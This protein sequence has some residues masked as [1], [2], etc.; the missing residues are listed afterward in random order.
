MMIKRL[1]TA[2]LGTRFDRER[3]RLEP[4]VEQIK[5]HEEQLRDLTDADLRAQTE[6][7]RARIAER[8]AAIREELESVRTAKHGA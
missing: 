4:V 3:K 6:R 5:R 2:V 8:T 7:F 1:M